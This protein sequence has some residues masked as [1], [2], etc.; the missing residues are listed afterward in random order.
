MTLLKQ[1]LKPTRGFW[2]KRENSWRTSYISL[3]S[4]LCL[5]RWAYILRKRRKKK[6]RWFTGQEIW[7]K[8]HGT[9]LFWPWKASSWWK[10][11]STIF[12]QSNH[13]DC[14]IRHSYTTHLV[15]YKKK[16]GLVWTCIYCNCNVYFFF[17]WVVV[18]FIPFLK[19]PKTRSICLGCCCNCASLH[20]F[21]HLRITRKPGCLL[22]NIIMLRRHFYGRTKQI[23]SCKLITNHDRKRNWNGNG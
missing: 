10:L 9:N 14:R 23:W 16:K 21:L 5:T 20:L 1:L 4:L 13:A 7:Q 17:F 15:K 18:Y 22:V 8:E 11:S 6:R 3:S 2:F 12:R 19:N